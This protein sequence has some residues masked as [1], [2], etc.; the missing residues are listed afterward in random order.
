MVEY[1]T[2]SSASQ[3]GDAWLAQVP[4]GGPASMEQAL[5]RHEG[6][7]HAMVRREGSG[8]LTY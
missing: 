2:H 6:L 3:V 1:T 5:D 7:I 8:S 4:A